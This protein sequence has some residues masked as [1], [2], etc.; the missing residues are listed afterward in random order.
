MTFGGFTMRKWFLVL[1]IGALFVFPSF[2][3]A[4]DKVA[5]QSINVQLWP[6]FD[7]AEMLVLNQIVFSSS[8]KFPIQFDVRIPADATIN[9]VAV[10]LSVESVSDQN[11][12][13]LAKKDG[14]W[15]VV[16]ITA[17][18]PAVR[19]EYYDPNLRKDGNLRTYSYRWLSDYDVSDFGV[20]FQQPFDAVKFQS[21]LPLQDE[22]INSINKM[23]YYSSDIGT[24]PAD[25][26]LVF[27]MNYEKPTDTL[28]VSHLDI[29]P[30]VVD[31]NTPGRVSF[32]NFL[33]YI[34]GGVGVILIVGGLVYYRESGRSGS[35]KSRRRQHAQADREENESG[36]YCSQCGTRARGGDRFCRTCGSRIRETEK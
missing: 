34:I 10:G 29:Q 25:K 28:S 24:A 4:Q 27:D 14:E 6:E 13:Y 33:P 20:A 8:A 22:G 26:M 12:K 35:K 9:T 31:E 36:V 7:R 32:N 2:A 21:S 1:V 5:I 19:I 30:M 15:S 16:S 11:V 23:Q 18:G 3:L 17:T